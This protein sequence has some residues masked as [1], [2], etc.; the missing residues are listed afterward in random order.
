MMDYDSQLKLQAYL[1]GELPEN[2][3]REV[4]G[5]V[6]KDR[7]AV[8]LL[9][10]LKATRQ[11]MA[12]FEI[13]IKLPESR[14]FYLSKIAR[15]IQVEKSLRPGRSGNVGERTSGEIGIHSVRGGDVVVIGFGHLRYVPE[16]A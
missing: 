12:D 16:N 7:E 1:D 13:G 3:A 6:A 11:A 8:A 15:Q 9:S 5:W 14:E 2:E 10:E 4:A